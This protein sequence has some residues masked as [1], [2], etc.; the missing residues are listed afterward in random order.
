MEMLHVKYD[1]HGT[2]K[3]PIEYYAKAIEN[4]PKQPL[5]NP[6]PQY[7]LTYIDNKY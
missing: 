1:E 4:Q 6:R 7:G 2:V 3:A 5:I